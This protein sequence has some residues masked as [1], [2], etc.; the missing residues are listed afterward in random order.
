MLEAGW[1]QFNQEY[2]QMR[3]EI[4]TKELE[5]LTNLLN[6]LV[7]AASV[8]AGFAFTALV[9]LEISMDTLVKLEEA[10]W[11]WIE[12]T[13]YLS[14]GMTIAFNLY[15]IV[16][17][18]MTTIRAQRM[19]L[20]G[21]VDSSLLKA[22]LPANLGYRP[23]AIG[24]HMGAQHDPASPTIRRMDST[25]QTDDVQRAIVAMRAVQPSILAAFGLSLCFFV[26]GAVAMVWIKT[27]PMHFVRTGHPNNHIAVALSSVFGCL[28]LVM[29]CVNVW[30]NKLFSIEQ[31]H[32]AQMR[33]AAGEHSAALRFSR[34]SRPKDLEQPLVG[35]PH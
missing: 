4:S 8:I 16:V 12:E 14:I 30:I 33:G 26:A 21:H 29:L 31:F 28:L 10:G 23:G 5:Y 13:Y 32:D 35:P 34:N 6:S 19:A 9:E 3:V 15:I 27:E 22:E 25:E 17:A 1:N 2:F 20:H 7:V 11:Y 24:D 18:T